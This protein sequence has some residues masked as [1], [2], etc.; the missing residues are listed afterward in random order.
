M[1][2]TGPLKRL[3]RG[4]GIRRT[5]EKIAA[6]QWDSL[7]RWKDC[8]AAMGFAGLL[9]KLQLGNGNCRRT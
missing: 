6:W 2:F 4:D 7:D 5:A 9:E 1:V 3:R 8:G